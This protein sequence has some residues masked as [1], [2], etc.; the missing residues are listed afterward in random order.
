M[1]AEAMTFSAAEAAVYDRQMR[2][3]GV[4]AQKRL[5]S[6]HV[7]VS[8]LSALGSELVK[9][10]V[11]AGLNVTVHDPRAVT[12]RATA[13][14]FFF[15]AE[16]IGRSRAEVALERAEELNPLVRVRHEVTPLS[17]LPDEFFHAFSAICLVGADKEAQLRLNALARARGIAFYAACS[18]GFDGVVFADLGKH[19]YRRTPTTSATSDGAAPPPTND[20]V[21]VEFPS[22]AAANDVA[23]GSLQST[24]KRGPQIP[25]VYVKYQLLQEYSAQKSVDN[26]AVAASADDFVAFAQALLEAQGLARDF[27]SAHDL[28]ALAQVSGVDLVPVCAI[29][30]GIL[31][32]EVVKAISQKDEPI[33]NYFCFDGAAGS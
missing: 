2:L 33:C 4:E 30:A 32:Q 27:F 29:V 6:S 5:Q 3:W 21:T 28:R 20:A 8:G 14:Q 13:A 12:P 7:L 17:G 22:L 24:R 10:L 1:A 16:D 31:G 15:A 25:R 26:G 19:V 11:L 23:W 9:N 18:F